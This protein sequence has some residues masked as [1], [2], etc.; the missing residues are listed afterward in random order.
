[1]K[2]FLLT[3]LLA[4]SF[5]G[6]AYADETVLNSGTI[7]DGDDLLIGV[8]DLGLHG[9]VGFM[10]C[11]NG[12]PGACTIFSTML[13]AKPGGGSDTLA[14]LLSAKLG[15]MG[16]AVAATAL[17]ANGT[18]CSA[19]S[20]PSGVDASGNAE[21]CTA[22]PASSRTTSAVSLS[23]VG[24]GATGTQISSTKDS[25]VRETI[26]TA[27]TASI[28]GAAVSTVVLKICAT[29]S[30]T[31]GDWTT[32]GTSETSQSY[33]LAVALQGVTGMKEE[34]EVDVPSGWYV[35]LENSGSGT[36]SESVIS[37]QKTIY[38]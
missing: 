25:T 9:P 11:V 14:N 33:S 37:G 18:N 12:N 17:A 29:N 22:V 13:F 16:T 10:A 34:L 6:P 19:G 24:T 36:H 26:S 2:K 35:K 1:M 21:G 3:A 15:T 23:L 7:G 31:E 38:N 27:A 4:F 20:Y 28:A 8:Y 30:A 5:I 32:Y